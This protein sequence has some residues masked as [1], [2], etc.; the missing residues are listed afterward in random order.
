MFG[1]RLLNH[2]VH[3]SSFGIV[4]LE[5]VCGRKNL[6]SAQEDDLIDM[7]KIK[8]EEDRLADLIDARNENIQ[9]PREEVVKMMKIAIWCLQPHF[10]RPS[11]STMV[12]VLHGLMDMEPINDYSFLTM[13]RIGGL[14]EAS[15]SVSAPPTAFI[16][17]GFR[18]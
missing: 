15:P 9:V 12:K 3:S 7:V 16:L 17:S 4:I 14:S 6:S 8:A 5:I 2:S 18:T 11:V 10:K 13:V 1:K